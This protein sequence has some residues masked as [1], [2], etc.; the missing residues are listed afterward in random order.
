M[1]NTIA[2]TTRRSNRML[3]CTSVT[4]RMHDDVSSNV[5]S[6]AMKK[7]YVAARSMSKST[8]I[9]TQL[10]SRSPPTTLQTTPPTTRRAPLL[11]P[12]CSKHFNGPVVSKSL[13]S[14]PTSEG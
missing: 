7:K 1:L 4:F 5:A 14:S 9:R 12:G 8:V 3:E 2:N 10:W 13:G 6:V 11:S